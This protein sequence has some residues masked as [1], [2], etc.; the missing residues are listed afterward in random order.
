MATQA[1]QSQDNSVRVT[2]AMTTIAE[3]FRDRGHGAYI[4]R[5]HSA[6]TPLNKIFLSNGVDAPR[7]IYVDGNALD[8]IYA[9]TLDNCVCYYPVA[10]STPSADGHLTFKTRGRKIHITHGCPHTVL[11][12]IRF[13]QDSR[14][15]EVCLAPNRVQLPRWVKPFPGAAVSV[16]I[17]ILT[18]ATIANTVVMHTLRKKNVRDLLA[19]QQFKVH[20]LRDRPDVA[21]CYDD[22]SKHAKAY[23]QV[24]LLIG[25]IPGRDAYP[26]DVFNLHADLLAVNGRIML[27]NVPL[28]YVI[29]MLIASDGVDYTLIELHEPT[30][31]AGRIYVVVVNGE[32]KFFSL[33]PFHADGRKVKGQ[34]ADHLIIMN[35]KPLFVTHSGDTRNVPIATVVGG[36]GFVKPITHTYRKSHR[37]QPLSK[38]LQCLLGE[39]LS[40][41][42]AYNSIVS[43]AGRGFH[44]L[45][46]VTILRG[47][48]RARFTLGMLRP[49]SSCTRRASTCVCSG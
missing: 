33:I 3:G 21:I 7:V 25:K 32:W 12:R 8:A 10:Q 49:S 1:S 16:L 42:A 24:S 23:R 17:D 2:S 5:A 47:S 26:A 22:L 11:A 46:E 4:K 45:T 40:P 13:T 9:V 29:A 15:S 35:G 48:K 14:P 28:E 19:L 43:V 38:K 31:L 20:S 41:G 6:V 27:V 18:N 39:L 30:R 37:L 44:P 36:D 34:Q